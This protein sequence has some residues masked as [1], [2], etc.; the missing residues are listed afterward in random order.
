MSW[1]GSLASSF[2]D[3]LAAPMSRLPSTLPLI[4]LCAL[5]DTPETGVW[6]GVVKGRAGGGAELVAVTRGT[7][8]K[9]GVGLLTTVLEDG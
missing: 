2:S 9:V 8:P 3:S 4:E 5:W 1:F 7:V 6:G